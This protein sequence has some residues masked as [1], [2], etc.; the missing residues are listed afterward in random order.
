M[1]FLHRGAHVR[2]GLERRLPVCGVTGRKADKAAG[3]EIEPPIEAADGWSLKWHGSDLVEG[4][5]RRDSDAHDRRQ[6]KFSS[7]RRCFERVRD[8]R[9]QCFAF[10][11]DQLRPVPG[12][13]TCGGAQLK[14]NDLN[15]L[16]LFVRCLPRVGF[17]RI[18][19]AG[20][21]VIC[22]CRSSGPRH[23]PN[24]GLKLLFLEPARRRC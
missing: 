15:G 4:L 24:R 12:E 22:I 13:E 16:S 7:M 11:R 5:T 1:K 14:P 9:R 8:E 17:E 2:R 19:V 18:E 6:T 3:T 10:G 23:R 20:A 21:V